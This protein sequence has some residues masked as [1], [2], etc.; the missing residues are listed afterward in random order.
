[1]VFGVEADQN[2]RRVAEK[3]GYEVYVGLFDAN[4]YPTDSFDYVTMDQVIEHVQDPIAVLRGVAQVLRPGGV[5]ILTTPNVAG[6][7]RKLFGRRWI[8]WHAPYHLQFFTAQSMRLAAEQ[9]GLVL[10]RTITTT[11]SAWLHF[12]WIHLLTCPPTGFPSAFWVQTVHL[13]LRQKLIVK[14]LSVL[15]SVKANHLMTRLL[16]ALGKG[17][18]RI[19]FMRKR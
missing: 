19:Y 16:D 8:N 13:T 1:M 2:I 9:A 12:Q 17:D 10:E 7:G 15:N 14:A 3:F 4:L 11:A 18:N 5:A 6:W